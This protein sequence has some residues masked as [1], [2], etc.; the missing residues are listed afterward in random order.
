MSNPCFVD[1]LEIEHNR[2]MELILDPDNISTCPCCTQEVNSYKTSIHQS[3]G[4]V[5]AN[6]YWLTSRRGD[7]YYQTSEAGIYTIV[8]GDFTKFKFWGFIDPCPVNENPKLKSSGKWRITG[9]GKEFI[10]GRI[11]VPKTAI[12]FNNKL[13]RHAGD[14]VSISDV[15]KTPFD[16][17]EINRN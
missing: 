2:L 7:G 16:Y 15:L 6:L 5:L 10:E 9:A 17:R 1:R 3:M 14:K 4:K 13:I 12:I 8:C 11:E